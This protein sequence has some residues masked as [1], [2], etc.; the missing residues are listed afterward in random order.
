MVKINGVYTLVDATWDDPVPDEKGKVYYNYF[1]VSDSQLAK[2][3]QWDTSKYPR[4]S[5]I[6]VNAI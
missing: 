6:Q 4:A 3:H 1:D 5:A 2:D